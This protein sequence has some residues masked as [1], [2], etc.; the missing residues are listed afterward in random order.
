MFNDHLRLIFPPPGKMQDDTLSRLDTQAIMHTPCVPQ[1]QLGSREGAEGETARHGS[2]SWG[3]GGRIL[4][5]ATHAAA[6]APRMSYSCATVRACVVVLQA[7]N[8][9]V[10]QLI[11]KVIVVLL[12]S[13]AAWS[14]RGPPRA[15][16]QLLANFTTLGWLQSQG[17]KKS[18]R[19]RQG[20]EEEEKK[21]EVL[22]MSEHKHRRNSA[23]NQVYRQNVFNPKHKFLSTFYTYFSMK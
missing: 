1:Q 8:E 18:E 11:R 19:G 14:G 5:K 15:F 13:Q 12:L 7:L 10:R 9:A 4:Y 17:L 22:K 23:H 20:E 6:A 3:A 16:A 21:K 2:V